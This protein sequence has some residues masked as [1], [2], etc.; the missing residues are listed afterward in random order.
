LEEGAGPSRSGDGRI[1]AGEH[2]RHG[3]SLGLDQLALPPD[4]LGQIRQPSPVH[5]RGSGYEKACLSSIVI[6]AGSIGKI[7]RPGKGFNQAG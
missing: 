1:G 7:S 4:L 2:L 6:P 5:R 3:P